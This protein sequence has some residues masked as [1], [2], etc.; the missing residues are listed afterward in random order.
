V[1]A[2]QPI[3]RNHV[4]RSADAD[5][6]SVEIVVRVRG[7]VAVTLSRLVE[8]LERLTSGQILAAGN[9]D[10]EFG[11]A[12]DGAAVADRDEVLDAEGVAALLKLPGTES[13]DRL[14]E[15]HRLP[16]FLIS[17]KRRFLRSS[18]FAFVKARE[19][20]ALSEDG[21]A[22]IVEAVAPRRSRNSPPKRSTK[23]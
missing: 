10:T 20:G 22:A 17:G 9:D 18:V 21:R 16:V 11:A 23:T 8:G 19:R 13:V 6:E 5:S 2:E 14:V 1:E 15:Q 3:L 4:D 12:T 7:A